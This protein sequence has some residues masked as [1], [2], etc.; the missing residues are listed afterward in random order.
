MFSQSGLENRELIGFLRDGYLIKQGELTPAMVA[1]LLRVLET[2]EEEP[3]DTL[4][5]GL[6]SS[7]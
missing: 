4:E 1:D 2:T 3:G 5:Q 6:D 7:A